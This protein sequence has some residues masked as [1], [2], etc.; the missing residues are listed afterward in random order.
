MESNRKSPKQWNK[1]GHEAHAFYSMSCLFL[2]RAWQLQWVAQA[3]RNT[4]PMPL[5]PFL[6]LRAGLVYLVTQTR[7][8][9]KGGPC[10]PTDSSEESGQLAGREDTG[11][12]RLRRDAGSL[13]VCSAVLALRPSG[14]KI[15]AHG[16]LTKAG[17]SHVLEKSLGNRKEAA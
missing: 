5:L 7:R 8:I 16:L 1:C 4:A 12:R 3:G 9:N 17:K 13:G 11:R 15:S 14:H 6:L 2:S 10:I